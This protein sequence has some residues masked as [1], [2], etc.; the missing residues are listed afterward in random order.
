MCKW[1]VRTLIR[2][3]QERGSSSSRISPTSPRPTAPTLENVGNGEALF[4]TRFSSLWQWVS[5]FLAKVVYSNGIEEDC[6]G[7][8]SGVADALRLSEGHKVPIQDQL[9]DSPALCMNDSTTAISRVVI[10]NR[11]ESHCLV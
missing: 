9:Q 11:R 10:S 1:N 8:P 2:K 7:K 3:L 5:T 4:E 6:Q